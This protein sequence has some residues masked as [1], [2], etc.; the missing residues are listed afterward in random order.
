MARDLRKPVGKEAKH[1]SVRGWLRYLAQWSGGPADT[2][3]SPEPRATPQEPPLSD[4]VEP[5]LVTPA[6]SREAI[7]ALS[8]YR[9]ALQ[10]LE[11]RSD[12]NYRAGR[13]E[14]AQEAL[15]QVP[16]PPALGSAV[17]ILRELFRTCEDLVFRGILI[18]GDQPAMLL[19]VDGMV[20]DE[21]IELSVLSPLTR[22]SPPQRLTGATLRQWLE[23]VAVPIAQ[24]TPL[25][26]I[27]QVVD[28]VLT[29]DAVLL[30]DGADRG[31]SLAT[32][33][34]PERA[35]EE[36]ISEANIRGPRD[37]F[38]ETMRT[39]TMLLRRRLQ[40]P[41]LKIERQVVGRRTRTLVAVAYLKD[42]AS[43]GIVT[44]VR[45]RISRLKVDGILDSGMLQELIEDQPSSPFPLMLDTERPDRVTAALLE[46]QVAVLVDGSPGAL[47]L[48]ATLW[49]FMRASEDYYN[50]F[51]IGT[52]VLWLRFLFLLLSLLGPSL[53]VAISSFHQEMLPTNLLLSIAAAREGVPFPVF[54][55]ALIME[56]FFE[57][58]RE[59][60]IRLPRQVGQAVSIV[61]ALVIGEAAVRAGLASAPVVIIVAATG[62]ASFTIPQFQ[63]GVTFRLLR[64][65]MMI[66]AGT[67]GLYGIMIGLLAI[68]VHLCAVRSF[69]VPYL[70]PIAP[71]DLSGLK[72]TVVRAP[73]W[74]MGRRPPGLGQVNRQRQ[75]D[76][77]KPGPG[78]G[79]P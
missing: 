34:W 61:G 78:G 9:E 47:L 7:H 59:A 28:S 38:T 53:Y 1:V 24:A 70:T 64:F 77:M 12:A 22:T 11:G 41:H 8:G 71:L 63:L 35:V 56:V 50:R 5:W 15:G 27:G 18:G 13:L 32:R 76:A 10:A 4:A 79:Q 57:A 49:H 54:I 14:Q 62:I 60:G 66:L 31:I 33:G 30:V 3:D 74:L 6:E 68:L 51:W 29:G 17:A 42:V 16:V 37:G 40:T 69:G 26:S 55:E 2:G 67:L 36:P 75:A 25:Q 23:T 44:E 20:T 72:D 21:R 48:P 39:N 73:L 65:P 19:Y 52:L 58:L 46:G 45:Q 43:P